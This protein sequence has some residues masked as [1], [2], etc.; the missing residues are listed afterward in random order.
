MIQ[1]PIFHDG[2]LVGWVGLS[3]HMMD[4]GGMVIGSFAPQATD[5]YQ[6]ALRLPPVRL[7][8][9]GEEMTDIWDILNNNVRMSELVEMDLRGLVAGCHLAQDRIEAVVESIGRARFVRKLASHPRPDRGR[10]APAHLRRGGRRLPLHLVDRVRGRLLPDPL[11]PHRRRRSH[12]L[13]LRGGLA[14]NRPLLQLQALHHRGRI[15][16]HAGSPH[17]PRPALQR[18][19]LRPYR[20]ALSARHHR[21]LVP[22]GPDR[23]RPHARGPQRGPTWP[24]RPSTWPW[25]PRPTR[26]PGA[27]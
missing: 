11:R 20:A 9:R 12:H 14:P 8:R 4:M 21:Q 27:I 7:F 17:R 22:T 26:R 3:A 5:C 1:R 23:R 18:G 10:D 2:E 15:R 25:G 19:H 13:G 16:G 24:C 6:E